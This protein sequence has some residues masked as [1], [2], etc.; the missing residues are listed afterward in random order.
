[1]KEPL[2]VYLQRLSQ[3]GRKCLPSSQS[4]WRLNAQG[5]L[6]YYRNSTNIDRLDYLPGSNGLR[7]IA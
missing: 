1:M 3:R 7:G 5:S 4:S 6:S 2:G